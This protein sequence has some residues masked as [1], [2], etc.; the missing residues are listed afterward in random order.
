MIIAVDFDGTIAHTSY[1]TILCEIS[2]IVD[3][4]KAWKSDGHTIILNTCRHGVELNN[5]V[6]WCKEELG[7]EFDY[8]NENCPEMIAVFGDTRKIFADIYLDDKNMSIDE[9]FLKDRRE[10]YF[11]TIKKYGR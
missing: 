4:V 10:K 5:A 8:V 3:Q 6:R 1:P 11:E 9:I 7:L 2:V